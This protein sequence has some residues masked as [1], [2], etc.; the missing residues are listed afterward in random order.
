MDDSE[1]LWRIEGSRA[2]AE[3]AAAAEE[4]EEEEGRG[5]MGVHGSNSIVAVGFVGNDCFFFCC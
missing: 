2:E 3:A 1:G 5:Q 4:E